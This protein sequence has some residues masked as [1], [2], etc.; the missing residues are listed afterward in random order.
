MCLIG[1]ADAQGYFA[2]RFGTGHHQMAGSLQTPSHHIGMWRLTNRQLELARE[3]RGASMRDGAEVP[4]VNGA[5]QIVVDVGSYA[6]DL[7]GRQAAPRGSVGARATFDLRLQDMRR[8]DERG[9][10]GLLIALQF[11]LGSFE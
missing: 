3:V 6:K 8:C 10:G 9:F 7:P 1:K 2:Q 11:S 5:V 4:G